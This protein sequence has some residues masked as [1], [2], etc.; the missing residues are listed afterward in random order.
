[1]SARDR[2]LD[3]GR[4]KLEEFRARKAARASSMKSPKATPVLGE[5]AASYTEKLEAKLAA[6]RAE[7][8]VGDDD[9]EES[10][11]TPPPPA[12]VEQSP[13]SAR[14]RPQVID[15]DYSVTLDRAA[16]VERVK[17]AT[18]EAL[19]EATADFASVND[20]IGALQADSIAGDVAG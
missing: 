7:S 18:A 3:N 1:M 13:E 17:T 15:E 8:V 19:K 12:K 5:N 2:D 14:M 11:S 16:E 9:V 6:L 20:A 4:K 10:A